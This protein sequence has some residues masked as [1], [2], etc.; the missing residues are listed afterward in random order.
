MTK[1]E[2]VAEIAKVTGS[3]KQDSERALNSVL[4]Q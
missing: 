4:I 3:T 1:A 2:L